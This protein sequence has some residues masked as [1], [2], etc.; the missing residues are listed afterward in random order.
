MLY[1]FIS[2]LSAFLPAA[3]LIGLTW[4]PRRDPS[5]ARLGW[6]LLLSILI[7]TVAGRLLPAMST[8]LLWS[9]ALQIA[10]TLLALAAQFGVRR[11]IAALTGRF[12][13]P[14]PPDSPTPTSDAIN[15]AVHQHQ[16][17]QATR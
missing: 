13:G 17:Q 16:H 6:T 9:S 4:A 2:V 3:L 11:F 7:G 10:L 15:R 1:Y 8:T 5:T 14:P 12:N